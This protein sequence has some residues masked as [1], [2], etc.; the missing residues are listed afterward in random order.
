MSRPR[1]PD[2][3]TTPP[4]SGWANWRWSPLVW[5]STQPSSSSRRISALTFIKGIVARAA[6]RGRGVF[7]WLS[8]SREGLAWSERTDEVKRAARGR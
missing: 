4:R 7:A 3:V 5:M 2:T 8:S 6:Q 1:F